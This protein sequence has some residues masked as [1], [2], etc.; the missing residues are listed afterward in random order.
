MPGRKILS[1]RYRVDTRRYRHGRVNWEQ[2][3]RE[4][5]MAIG[6]RETRVESARYNNNSIR[7]RAR[8]RM[9]LEEIIPRSR[10]PAIPLDY[11]SMIGSCESLLFSELAP[12]ASSIASS[13]C[14]VSCISQRW[15]RS[16][17]IPSPGCYLALSIY[18]YI[19]I[20]NCL[21]TNNVKPCSTF[22]FPFS[23]M[24]L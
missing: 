18:R 24:A 8:A 21:E 6:A 17:R 15:I 23:I 11:P 16:A 1:R 20:R 7:A 10:S 19:A 14:T 9:S 2:R 5:A 12:Y 3:V 22:H 4:R 13:R